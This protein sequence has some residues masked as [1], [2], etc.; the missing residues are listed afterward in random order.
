MLCVVVLVAE[1]GK[2]QRFQGLWDKEGKLDFNRSNAKPIFTKKIPSHRFQTPHQASRKPEVSSR[3]NIFEI[4]PKLEALDPKYYQEIQQSKLDRS[5]AGISCAGLQSRRLQTM[6]FHKS[7]PWEGKQEQ[8]NNDKLY[9]YHP[10]VKQ[11][12]SC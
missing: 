9:T 7:I 3:T 5:V 8:I 2:F 6:L 11:T 4:R 10:G 12:A 1:K